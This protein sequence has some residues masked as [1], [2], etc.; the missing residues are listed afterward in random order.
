MLT[1]LNATCL[2]AYLPEC[3]PAWM[4][5]CLNAYLPEC[6]SAWMLICLNAYLPECLSAWNAYLSECLSAWMFTCLSA[7]MH[8]CLQ[9]GTSVL[10][11]QTILIRIW[12]RLFTLMPLRIWRKKTPLCLAGAS[13]LV[14]AS[15]FRTVWGRICKELYKGVAVHRICS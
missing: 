12:I 4:L 2:N 6:L 14:Q 1:W 8:E 9:K 7:Y 5:T 10:W 15:Y 13:R 11:I 3:L